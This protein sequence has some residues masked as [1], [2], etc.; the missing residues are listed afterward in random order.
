MVYER[1]DRRGRGGAAA[2]CCCCFP[3]RTGCTIVAVVGIVVACLS[4]ASA[5]DAIVHMDDLHLILGRIGD[6]AKEAY[7]DGHITRANYEQ[8]EWLSEQVQDA[9]PGLFTVEMIMAVLGLIFC[10]ALLIGVVKEKRLL[11]IPFLVVFML[12]IITQSMLFISAAVIAGIFVGALAS[13][14]ILLL[15]APFLAL[16]V[17]IWHV[18]LRYYRQLLHREREREDLPLVETPLTTMAA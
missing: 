10:A 17:Y 5:A 6:Q 1:F 2:K 11:C 8:I 12:E 9:I 13:F 14:L 7:A 4:V 16:Y 18:V 15:S 3:L